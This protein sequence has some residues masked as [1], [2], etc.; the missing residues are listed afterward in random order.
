[1]SIDQQLIRSLTIRAGDGLRCHNI[2]QWFKRGVC[3]LESAAAAGIIHEL[4]YKE[5]WAII[6]TSRWP[7]FLPDTFEG[8]ESIPVPARTCLPLAE[9]FRVAILAN[10]NPVWLRAL[11]MA[12]L[13]TAGI[14][15][16]AENCPLGDEQRVMS[17]LVALGSQSAAIICR[18]Q[19]SR[20]VMVEALQI[21]R[22]EGRARSTLLAVI[23][24]TR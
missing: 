19:L 1:M 8:P 23:G 22:D 24:A 3:K 4:Q 16:I 15:Q 14:K 13:T 11:P 12:P 2:M 9:H 5:E 10:R 6:K 18:L 20:R 7:L 21:L 17:Q